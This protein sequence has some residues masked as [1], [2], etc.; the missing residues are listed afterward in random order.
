MMLICWKSV[1]QFFHCVILP[2]IN[3]YTAKMPKNLFLRTINT[4]QNLGR[5]VFIWQRY[6]YTFLVSLISL[7]LFHRYLWT[8]ETYL[9]YFSPVRNA[10][11][12]PAFA[13]IT[14]VAA[15]K[16]DC[17]TNTDL[18]SSTPRSCSVV[19]R[20]EHISKKKKKRIV[21]MTMAKPAHEMTG[22]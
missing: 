7:Y 19:L 20:N 6:Y 5:I 18:R 4:V 2:D 16:R 22:A 15:N 8:Q 14:R 9:I 13:S 10:R 1:H 17:G 21:Q 3:L 11:F 12:R